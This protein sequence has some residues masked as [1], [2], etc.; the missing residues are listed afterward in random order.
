MVVVVGL[1]LWIRP[2]HITW[3]ADFQHTNKHVIWVPQ[4]EICFDYLS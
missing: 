3:G 2:Y 4:M 1:G